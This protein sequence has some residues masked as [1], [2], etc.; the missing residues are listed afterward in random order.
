MEIVKENGLAV[1]SAE[2][3]RRPRAMDGTVSV[4]PRKKAA[5]VSDQDL[6]K[7]ENDLRT[8]AKTLYKGIEENYWDLGQCLYDVYDGVPGGYR[9]LL[10]GNGSRTARR[11]LFEKWGY[12]SFEE[13]CE[14]EV[15]ILR[16]SATNLRYA[17]YWFEIKLNL[18]KELKDQIKSL[19][20]SK[21]YQ[22]SGFVGMDNIMS[23]IEK[24]KEMTHDELAKSIKAAKAA[25][26]ERSSDGP[27]EASDNGDS[28]NED[29]DGA[30]VP[31][32]PE[33][34]HNLQTSLYEG[35]WQTW[36][37]AHER[38]KG[39]SGSEKI[40]HNLELICQDFLMNN[41]FGKTKEFDQKSYIAKI[42]RQLGLKIV[43]IN[44]RDGKPVYG[45]DILWMLV[46]E[47][48]DASKEMGDN[49]TEL[50]PSKKRVAKQED[51]TEE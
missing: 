38:A 35:Q 49:V 29:S 40:G 28:E 27:E 17:Y 34:T 5:D 51:T 37:A 12:K 24:A 26:A 20:R 15:G 2:D 31:P 42:E 1:M 8:R 36:Q 3:D 4:V 16:R 22:L 19:G 30:K 41:D 18:P 11:A 10:K 39:L 13:Y 44:P 47:R 7:A 6:E 46:Q 9:E 33:T 45:G 21:V 32:A 50:K 48:A 43:A 14:K 25:K 23:W